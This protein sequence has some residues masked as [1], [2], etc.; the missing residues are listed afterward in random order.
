MQSIGSWI[1]LSTVK[2]NIYHLLKILKWLGTDDRQAVDYEPQPAC[3]QPAFCPADRLPVKPAK[4]VLFLS[5]TESKTFSHQ[6]IFPYQ[7]NIR[8]FQGLEAAL[9]RPSCR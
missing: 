9:E 7:P 2:M 5:N 1:V 3:S 4:R 6:I 8:I